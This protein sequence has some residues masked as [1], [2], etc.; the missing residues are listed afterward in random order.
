M[1]MTP[2]SDQSPLPSLKAEASA[3]F[4]END[5]VKVV[6]SSGNRLNSIQHLQKIRIGELFSPEL[7]KSPLFIN[8]TKK[9]ELGHTY[10]MAQ[11]QNMFLEEINTPVLLALPQEAK[12]MLHTHLEEIEGVS[13]LV[14]EATITQGEN[15][16]TRK[17][18]YPTADQTIP[19]LKKKI[20]DSKLFE[21]DVLLA[22]AEFLKKY[23]V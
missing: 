20:I 11:A 13:H 1:A 18:S 16:L 15:A 9:K 22:K 23:A 10:E 19:A 21:K 3:V 12:L 5:L 6:E 14:I 4:Q 17:S 2:P 8:R 7:L